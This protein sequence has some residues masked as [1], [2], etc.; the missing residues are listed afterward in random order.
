MLSYLARLILT[1]SAQNMICATVLN[2][3][4]MTTTDNK[5]QIFLG[6]VSGTTAYTILVSCKIATERLRSTY[7]PTHKL[8]VSFLE[9]HRITRESVQVILQIAEVQTPRPCMSSGALPETFLKIPKTLAT[10]AIRI[11]YKLS[12]IV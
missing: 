1:P 2:Q 10:D 8:L 5:L 6:M 3:T 4:A 12:L 7:I 11:T 9:Q